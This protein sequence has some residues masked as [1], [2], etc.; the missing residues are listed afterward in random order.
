MQTN[1]NVPVDV[2]V[3]DHSASDA[4]ITLLAIRRAAPN[5]T[6]VHLEDGDQALQFIFCAGSYRERPPKNP[7]LILLELELPSIN[8]LQV[9]DTVRQHTSTREIPVVLLT[10]AL[11]PFALASAHALGA[12][13]Y[14]VKPVRFE[15]YCAEVTGILQTLQRNPGAQPLNDRCRTPGARMAWL[16]RAGTLAAS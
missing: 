2:L 12:N 5:T 4:D 1:N 7:R 9:L 13:G 15:R 8:G 6:A 11:N 3:V 10:S 16:P 14:I